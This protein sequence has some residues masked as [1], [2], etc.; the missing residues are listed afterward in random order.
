MN[1]KILLLTIGHIMY[2]DQIGD[3]RIFRTDQRF[4]LAFFRE[5]SDR[6]I[7]FPCLPRISGNDRIPTIDTGGLKCTRHDTPST[8]LSRRDFRSDPGAVRLSRR[9]FSH[10]KRGGSNLTRSEIS[11]PGMASPGKVVTRLLRYVPEMVIERSVLVKIVRG[12]S[13]PHSRAGTT[14]V[15]VH[16]Q[17]AR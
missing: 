13:L 17:P 15:R 16:K 2:E 14:A 3:N 10:W 7:R 1:K 6:R 5:R 9:H 12:K 4:R 11:K 8:K